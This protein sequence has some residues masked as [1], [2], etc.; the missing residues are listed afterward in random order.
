MSTEYINVIVEGAERVLTDRL[1]IKGHFFYIGIIWELL[2]YVRWAAMKSL[3]IE[4]WVK[5]EKGL[6]CTSFVT[7]LHIRNQSDG[8]P[9]IAPNFLK[10]LI[11]N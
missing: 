3:E 2:V 6:E 11:F 9:T 7:Y 8:T 5:T 4:E 1:Q 10:K